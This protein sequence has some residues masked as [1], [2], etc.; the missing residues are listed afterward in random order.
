MVYKLRSTES[1]WDKILLGHSEIHK[2]VYNASKKCD[3]L[4]KAELVNYL[5]GEMAPRFE[6]IIQ[7]RISPH[8]FSIH[9]FFQAPLANNSEFKWILAFLFGW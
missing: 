5:K 7:H 9:E 8:E 1:T 3:K 2:G 6:P 4:P